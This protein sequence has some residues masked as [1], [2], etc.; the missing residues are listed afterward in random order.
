MDENAALVT[1]TDNY[2]YSDPWHYNSA[3]YLDLG[4]QFADALVEK[5]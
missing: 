4:R 2:G 3:G 1:S 5:K